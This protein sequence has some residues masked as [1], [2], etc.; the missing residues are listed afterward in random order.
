MIPLNDA[1]RRPTTFPIVTLSIIIVNFAVFVVEL[2]NGDAF[3]EKWSVIPAHISS[4][5]DLITVLSAMFMHASWSHIIGNMVFLWAFGPEIE[6]S[7][8]PGRYLIFYLLGGLAATA[9]QVAFAPHSTV[10]NLGA[11]GAIAAVMGA[12]LVTFPRDQI[13]T[14]LVLVVFITIA[15][16]PSVILIGFWFLTQLWN[17]GQ[18]APHEST[19][20]AYLAHI[21]G[22]MFGAVFARLFERRTAVSD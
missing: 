15:Y 11:S 18:I 16:V 9:T 21:G 3:V 2:M 8:G 12:F 6:D 13:R 19:G 20:V 17:A 7:M 14:I 1:S 4:G 10:P 5:H 22:F